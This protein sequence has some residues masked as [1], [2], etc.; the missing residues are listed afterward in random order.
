MSNSI[1]ILLKRNLDVFGEND[2]TRR[3]AAIDEIFTEDCV[4]YDPNNGVYRGRDEIDKIAGQIKATHPDFQY[5][6]IAEPDV[7][8]DGGRIQWVSGRPGNAPAYAGTDFIVARE[9]RIAAVYLF[10]DKLP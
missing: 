5:R 6:Q 4:F 1:S 10:F 7:S 8:G 2:P 3:R 9:G